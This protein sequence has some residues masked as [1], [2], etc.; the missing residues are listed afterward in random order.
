MQ[1]VGEISNTFQKWVKFDLLLQSNC[2]CTKKHRFHGFVF[3]SPYI[4][5]VEKTFVK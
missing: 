1:P 3:S 5:V 2:K 4:P